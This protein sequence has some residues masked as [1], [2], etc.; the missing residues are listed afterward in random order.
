MEIRLTL[1]EV[2]SIDGGGAVTLRCL[3]GIVWVTRPGDP[4][5]YFLRAGEELRLGSAGPAVVEAHRAAR[6]A[7]NRC[8]ELPATAAGRRGQ[9]SCSFPAPLTAPLP[10]S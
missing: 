8:R 1:N 5:D 10:H 7:L 6:I 2:M 4:R 3:E 9:V